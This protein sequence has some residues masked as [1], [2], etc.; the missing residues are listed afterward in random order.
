M[1]V[2]AGIV[3]SVVSVVVPVAEPSAQTS[4]LAKLSAVIA[5]Y[6]VSLVPAGQPAVGTRLIADAVGGVTGVTGATGAVG[7]PGDEI[8]VSEH[9]TRTSAD[10]LADAKS[11]NVLLKVILWPLDQ[12][13]L[14]YDDKWRGFMWFPRTPCLI[15]LMPV[16]DNALVTLWLRFHD[17]SA[18]FLGQNFT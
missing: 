15:G 1:V 14:K 3:M 8:V 2:L 11:F 12:V 10:T 9:A 16:N 7:I 5:A 17:N 6:V 13:K 18:V 4:M